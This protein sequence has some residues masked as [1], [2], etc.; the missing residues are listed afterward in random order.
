MTDQKMNNQSVPYE[1]ST[2]Q[3]VA[4]T[5][6]TQPL[7]IKQS[8]TQRLGSWVHAARSSSMPAWRQRFMTSAYYTA[9]IVMIAFIIWLTAMIILVVVFRFV[10]PPTSALMLLRGMSGVQVEQNWVD[11]NKISPNLIRAVIVSEDGRFCSHWGIDPRELLEAIRR[12]RNGTPRGA[13]T[14]TMQ[15]TK[16]LFLWPSKSYIR[17]ALEVP[18]TLAIE[19]TWPKRRIMEVYLNIV[20][21]GP[22]IFGVGRAARYHF[23]LR[24][25][26]L[27]LRQ[28]S[29]LAV[30]L[31][32]PFRRRAGAP[33]PG[34]SRLATVI[35]NRARRNGRAASCV[36]RRK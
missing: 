1:D 11:I 4:P 24:A 3:N 13:S 21:W 31:P 10:N 35:M 8:L 29:L 20:E 30:S 2:S 15:L 7:S 28:A 25:R 16:N 5:A 18:L 9:W 17:K 34:L 36:L 27:Q 26:Q 32:N 14:I 22:G 19:L 6:P 12:S 23:G 33:G